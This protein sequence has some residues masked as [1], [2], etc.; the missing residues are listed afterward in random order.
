LEINCSSEKLRPLRIDATGLLHKAIAADNNIM[1]EGA[2][3]TF[4]DIDH[5]TYPF[6]TSSN[7]TA[8]AVC[9]GSGIGPRDIDHVLGIVKAYTTRVGS[10][11]FPTELND[12]VGENIRKIGHEFG[13]VTGRPRRCGWLD[14]VMLRRANQLNS[15]TSLCITK[16]DVLDNM[17]TVKIC[18]AYRFDGVDYTD[19]NDLPLDVNFDQCQPVYLELPGWK[20]TA[21]AKNYA[22]LPENAR[23]FLTRVEQLAGVPISIISVGADRKNTLVLANPFTAELNPELSPIQQLNKGSQKKYRPSLFGSQEGIPA[24]TVRDALELTAPAAPSN[25]Q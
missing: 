11:P 4:L 12:D 8:G 25:K 13:S 20:S 3:G 16:L 2:Q 1:F 15:T 10:G 7:T 17:D 19:L 18:T 22:D 6:V 24:P 23:N 9:T 21:Q 5:G 14:M